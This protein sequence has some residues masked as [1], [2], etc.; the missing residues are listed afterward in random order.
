MRHFYATGLLGGIGRMFDA[1]IRTSLKRLKAIEDRGHELTRWRVNEIL[2]CSSYYDAFIFEQDGVLTEQLF[3]EY[4]GLNLSFPPHV[5]HAASP[6]EAMSALAERPFDMVIIMP[7][8]GDKT[9]AELASDI[10]SSHPELP[11]LLLLN[12][13]SDR[14]W[15]E[16]SAHGVVDDIFLWSGDSKVF[17]AMIKSIEDRHNLRHD[18]S[19]GNVRVILVVEDSIQHYSYFLPLLYSQIVKQTQLLI[20]EGASESVR[21]ARMRTRPKVIAV[22]DFDA[23]AQAFAEYKDYLIGIIS[24]VQYRR[25]GEMDDQAGVAFLEMVRRE[26]ATLPVLLQSAEP[27]N[28]ARAE[29][30]GAFFA[31]KNSSWLTAALKD[32]IVTQLGFGDFVFRLPDDGDVE[33][34]SSID[35]FIDAL[36]RVPVESVAWHSRYNHFSGWLMAH[37]EIDFA[38]RIQPLSVSNFDSVE[39]VRQYLLKVFEEV[40]RAANR[41]KVVDVVD[42]ERTERAEIVRLCPGSMGGK[43]RGLAFLNSSLNMMAMAE[44][45]PD[46]DISLPLTA[47]VGTSE[48]DDFIE[49]NGIEG[50]LDD[51]SDDGIRERFLAGGLSQNLKKSLL[52]LVQ[53]IDVPLAVRSSG[54]LEDSQACPLAGVYRTVMVPNSSPEI[55]TRYHELCKAV[56]LVFSSVFERRSREFLAGSRFKP[57]DEKMAVIIQEMVGRRH[58]DYF[59]PDI[60]G[61][62]QSYNFY[63]TG[64]L[65]ASDGIAGIALGLGRT[66]VDGGRIFRFCPA[67]PLTDILTARDLMSNAQKDFWALRLD[68]L[69]SG[70]V[71]DEVDTMARLSLADAEKHGV[72]KSLASRWDMFNET[73]VTDLDGPGPRVLDFARVL[74]YGGFP[75]PGIVQDVMALGE[76]AFGLPVEV[77]FATNISPGPSGRREFFVLQIR[78]L[79]INKTFVEVPVMAGDSRAPGVFLY[80]G[81]SLGNGEVHGVRDVVVVDPASFVTTETLAMKDEISAFNAS[82]REAGNGYVLIGP[83]R[84]GSSDRFL[85]VPVIWA[86]ISEAVAIVEMDLP[87]FRVESSQG[88]HFFHNLVARNAGCMKIRHQHAG[89][90]VDLDM[91]A[92][93]EVVGRTA[94]C[95]HYRTPSPLTITMDGRTGRAM[96][97]CCQGEG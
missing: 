63:P 78:P 7:R 57:R 38:R 97:V 47:F 27:A 53:G 82:M 61:V 31:D 96:I 91:A 6:A 75:L 79:T 29:S 23:A 35:E 10:K 14:T 77:E 83:G 62:A 76:E 2:L 17:L 11:V 60:S 16:G 81:E 41:G 8:V 58:G 34:V 70:M 87:D 88:T 55:G 67:F 40:R 15:V 74:K 3:G 51:L 43:G 72:L 1:E 92:G 45:Y 39:D 73:M 26:R 90:W 21:R 71:D 80:S 46:V 12:N 66:I 52:E 37:G 95:V 49:N 65:R 93:W 9:F 22:H 48:Y 24:D 30:L 5:R 68:A 32:F 89:S 19:V 54:L 44:R 59:Y 18:T 4:S 13:L 86:D 69:V 25:G 42:W 84:W 64:S 20:N 94:H 33:V 85:G 50:E 28:R 36:A 56:K